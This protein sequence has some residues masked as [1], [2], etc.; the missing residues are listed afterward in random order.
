M[1]TQ[2]DRDDEALFGNLDGPTFCG[3]RGHRGRPAVLSQTTVKLLVGLLAGGGL[4]VLARI[5][6]QRV[7]EQWG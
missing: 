7:S 1:P 4:D 3:D 5:V 6:R 2:K